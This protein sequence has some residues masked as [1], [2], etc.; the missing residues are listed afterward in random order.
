MRS[1]THPIAVSLAVAAVTPYIAL[2]VLWLGGSTVGLKTDASVGEMH[3]ARMVSGNVVTIGLELL[4]IGLI[5]ALTRGWGSRGSAG[6]FLCL[7]AGATGLLAPILLGLPIGSLLQFVAHGDVH[8]S[9]MDELA[10]WVFAVVYG[11]FVLLA[12]VI[13]ALGWH[14]ARVRWAD[15]LSRHP[16]RPASWAVVAGAVGMLPF[17]VGM[18]WWSVCGPGNDGPQQMEEIAQRVVLG[19]TGLLVVAG[20]VA[21]LLRAAPERRQPL[22]WIALWCG[23][24]TAAL[25][26]PTQVL[27]ASDGRAS[28]ALIAL[29]VAAV[30]GAAAY[31]S[32]AL[33]SS[34]AGRPT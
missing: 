26:G 13:G 5:V 9:G 22:A 25:Q 3:S 28:V 11:G 18:L 29:G 2:K 16:G 21:P 17:A 10:G 6:V 15:L 8:T 33:R 4:A 24:T 32:A 7:A 12:V 30:T 14:A 31:G 19:M 27:L 1:R 23:C 20:F 34:L